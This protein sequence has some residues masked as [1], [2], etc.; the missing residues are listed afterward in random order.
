MKKQ[1][2]TQ[3]QNGNTVT[4]PVGEVPSIAMDKDFYHYASIIVNLLRSGC[5]F[6]QAINNVRFGSQGGYEISLESL[7]EHLK[8]LQLSKEKFTVLV[9]SKTTIIKIERKIMV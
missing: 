7:E 1:F 3:S 2:I 4:I 9:N 5:P 6:V 8:D